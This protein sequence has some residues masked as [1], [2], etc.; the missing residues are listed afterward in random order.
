[1]RPAWAE[2][3]ELIKSAPYKSQFH[4]HRG[5]GLKPGENEKRTFEANAP[6]EKAAPEG[7]PFWGGTRMLSELEY[8]G[9]DGSGQWIHCEPD[10]TDNPA[11]RALSAGLSVVLTPCART[12]VARGQFGLSHNPALNPNKNRRASVLLNRFR[13]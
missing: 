11:R 8:S 12:A 5:T 6:P 10:Q 4:S 9:G 7:Q 2:S 13:F 1:M 3:S